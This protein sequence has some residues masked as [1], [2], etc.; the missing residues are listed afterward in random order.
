[1]SSKAFNPFVMAQMQFDKA[2][3]F[4]NLDEGTRELLQKSR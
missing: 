3:E 2:A 1:M 4:L